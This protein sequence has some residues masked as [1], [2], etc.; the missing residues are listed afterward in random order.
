[1]SPRFQK[2]LAKIISAYQEG[3]S[4]KPLLDSADG[5]VLNFLL[6]MAL[7]ILENQSSEVS[8]REE[9][10]ATILGLFDAI[11][12]Q[13]S[14]ISGNALQALF[15]DLGREDSKGNRSGNVT[16]SSPRNATYDARR[17]EG[18][19]PNT[20]HNWI[21]PYALL[22]ASDA[23]DS[24]ENQLKIHTVILNLLRDPDSVF[25]VGRAQKRASD[26]F[27]Y[28]K[29]QAWSP[30]HLYID[31]DPAITE[32]LLNAAGIVRVL[33]PERKHWLP[34]S[35]AVSHL[36]LHPGEIE[37]AA[38]REILSEMLRKNPDESF[39]IGEEWK[40]ISD[41][42]AW[43][44]N[45]GPAGN[46]LY[47]DPAFLDAKRSDLIDSINQERNPH[48]FF[49]APYD[50]ARI[51][52]INI[53]SEDITALKKVLQQ[54]LDSGAGRII[55]L[56]PEGDIP[57]TQ[58]PLSEVI[59]ILSQS[60]REALYTDRRAVPSLEE[61]I[62]RD[63]RKIRFPTADWI[64][65]Y[66]VKQQIDGKVDGLIQR[67]VREALRH[68][69]NNNGEEKIVVKGQEIAVKDVFYTF[70]GPKGLAMKIMPEAVES[71]IP[72]IQQAVESVRNP[73][74]EGR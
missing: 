73:K 30:T 56:A 36:S 67:N 70:S 33:P 28:G 47:V 25:E 32:F 60:G 71:L 34:V 65:P 24:P 62:V 39:K 52:G 48:H 17:S 45:T 55:P 26:V 53:K 4:I 41:L 35:D 22:R 57:E 38:L 19:L 66:T 10:V 49:L 42:I 44:A 9:K 31:P 16:V 74:R 23:T 1:M 7:S 59:K 3:E 12:L 15:S 8:T 50:L 27:A 72:F 2:D 29:K 43:H 69:F 40:D 64:D 20:K 6:R 18:V 37:I 61:E 13:S 58:K 46:K 63:F 14:G 11:E 68:V 51:L 21:T 54:L 5:N